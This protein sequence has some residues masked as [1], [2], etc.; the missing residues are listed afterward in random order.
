M[1]IAAAIGGSAQID[2]RCTRRM[3]LAYGITGRL[4]PAARLEARPTSMVTADA[5]V[6]KRRRAENERIKKPTRAAQPWWVLSMQ[7]GSC[8]G[9]Q[10][11]LS[12]DS[13]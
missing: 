1:R 11:L 3:K 12:Y 2:R 5:E 4:T 10:T 9:L 8:Q 6:R 7:Y 13:D